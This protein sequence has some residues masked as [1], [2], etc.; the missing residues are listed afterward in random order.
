VVSHFAWAKVDLLDAKGSVKELGDPMLWAIHS[1]Y[2][3]GGATL[4]LGFAL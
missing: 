1:F 4:S 3:A 2:A